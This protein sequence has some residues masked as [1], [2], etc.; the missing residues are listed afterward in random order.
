MNYSG[1]PIYKAMALMSAKNKKIAPELAII[2][3]ER[4][5]SKLVRALGGY[6]IYIPREKEFDK[7][8]LILNLLDL[9]ANGGSPEA[10]REFIQKRKISQY[11]LRFIKTE[12]LRY[13]RFKR[14]CKNH[15]LAAVI[16]SRQE[17]ISKLLRILK[18]KGRN[19]E[20]V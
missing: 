9:V 8:L 12:L 1:M 13:R 19:N 7:Y 14:V 4:Q 3:D 20:K 10:V 6:K 5:M 18:G 11:T 17:A 16:G 2:F 15:Y